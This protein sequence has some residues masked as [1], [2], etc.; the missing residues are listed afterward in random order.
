[1]DQAVEKGLLFVEGSGPTYA[2][3]TVIS[4]PRTL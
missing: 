2:T 4:L 1:M 3:A